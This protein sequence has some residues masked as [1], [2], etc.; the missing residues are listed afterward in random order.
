[1]KKKEHI[2]FDNTNV[3]EEDYRE[4]FEDYCEMNGYEE[5]EKDLSEYVQETLDMYLE[6]EYANLNKELNGNILVIA[7][8]GFWDGRRSG[9][10]IINRNN[11]NAI[12]N[13]L[14]SDYGYF[15]FYCDRY[16]VKAELHHHDG[17]H[18]LTFREIREGKDITNLTDKLYEQEE[19]TQKEITRYTKSLKPYVKQIYGW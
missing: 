3:N 5:G 8:L 6:D 7:D 14:G 13:V 11:L 18:Y 10:Q 15:K 4:A 12:F 16:D 2:I 1:M 19:V 17:T 9:Y